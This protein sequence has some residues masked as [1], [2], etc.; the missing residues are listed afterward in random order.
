[1]SAVNYIVD[2]YNN[3]KEIHKVVVHR[4]RMGDVE[5]PDLYVAQPIWEWQNSKQGKFIMENSVETPSWHRY[6][7]MFDFGW[8]YAIVAELDS[9]KLTEFYLRWGNPDGSDK[10]R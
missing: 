10:I 3:V 7:S 4:I 6:N 9:K 1:M 2:D 5:D 8:T